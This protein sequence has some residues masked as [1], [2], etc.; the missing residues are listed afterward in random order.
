[1]LRSISKG[2]HLLH[3]APARRGASS[4]PAALSEIGAHRFDDYKMRQH[5]APEVYERFND[6][7]WHGKDLSKDDK[8]AVR[9]FARLFLAAWLLNWGC[10]YAAAQV[11]KAMFAWAT[12]LGAV[13]YAHH[14]SPMRASGLG[15]GGTSAYKHD[16]FVS[17]DFSSSHAIKPIITTFSGTQLF[18]SE[19]HTSELHS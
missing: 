3:C 16:A 6:A 10:V 19:E 11:A 12:S 13:N 5:L 15:L 17:L 14:F 7:T 1:M 4:L 9:G 8:D 18:R 2:R